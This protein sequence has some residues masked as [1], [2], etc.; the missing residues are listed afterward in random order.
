MSLS[1]RW[2]DAHF[3]EIPRAECLELL[4]S[5]PV[6]RVAY[7]DLNGPV[8]LPVNHVVEGEDIIFR[9]SPHTELARQI[10]K[11]HI[12]F[13]VDDFDA[14]N[15]SGWSVLVHGSAEYED[16]VETRPLDRPEPWA[17]G[18]R[19]LIVRITPRLITGRRVSPRGDASQVV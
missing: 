11:G 9:T 5:Q 17:D 14:G 8:V 13:E 7:C 4:A 16:S 10:R 3:Q 19:P 18:F 1:N 2:F 15:Q 6:G 12:A